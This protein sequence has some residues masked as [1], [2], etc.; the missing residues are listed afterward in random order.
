MTDDFDCQRCGACCT[1][2][3]D[4]K[5][6]EVT[7]SDAIRIDPSLLQS[8]DI[9]TFAMRQRE[10]GCCIALQGDVNSLCRCMIYENRPTICRTVQQGDDICLERR[11][12]Y[13]ISGIDLASKT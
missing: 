10:D 5:W 6:V 7:E 9:E 8:G 13:N 11:A 3:E 12:V 4:N 2:K 1:N